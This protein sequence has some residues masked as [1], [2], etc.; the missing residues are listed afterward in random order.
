MFKL[1]WNSLKTE[2]LI[3]VKV[4]ESALLALF[5]VKRRYQ[6]GTVLGKG[7]GMNM[8]SIVIISAGLPAGW[9]CLVS[10]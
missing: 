5:H 3:G 10:R 1:L 9:D 6:S 8:K 4:E 7:M 2:G